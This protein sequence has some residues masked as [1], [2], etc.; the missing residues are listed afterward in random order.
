[1]SLEPKKSPAP[2][3]LRSDAELAGAALAWAA[4]GGKGGAL[5]REIAATV[6]RRQRRRRATV[7]S[8]TCAALLIFG[9]LWLAPTRTRVAPVAAP[10]AAAPA[11]KALP[12]GSRVELRP[13]ARIA[14]DFSVGARHVTLLAGEAYFAVSKDPARPFTVAAHG[15][16]VRAVGTEF[17]VDLTAGRV[18]VIVTEGR[19]A[20]GQS[21]N[22][23]AAAQPLATLDAG[24]RVVVDSVG[25]TP[26]AV[27]KIS[28][29]AIAAEHAWRVPRLELAGTPLAEVVALF[30]RHGPVRLTLDP[31][32]ADLRLGGAL[33]ADNTDA[34]L[35]LLADEFGIVAESREGTLQLRRP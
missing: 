11:V 27:E 2:T 24:D 17:S 33:R 7:V 12:D 5:S 15:V 25:A 9:V 6:G 19:V 34:L 10:A 18:E 28:K 13:G 23:T 30:N 14:V 16:E 29:A 35:R 31:A 8:A 1:M 32:L 26:L 4:G 20:V 22:P 3:A 21:A